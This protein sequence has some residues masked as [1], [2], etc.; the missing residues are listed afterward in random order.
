MLSD[1]DIRKA[2]AEGWVKI[3]P[4]NEADI[5]PSWVILHLGENFLI[6]RR[7]IKAIRPDLNGGMENYQP[8]NATPANPLILRPGDFV[9]GETLEKVSVGKQLGMVLS[10]K[11]AIARHGLTGDFTSPFIETG[12]GV[13]NPRHI[14][15]EIKN[16]SQNVIALVPGIPFTKGYFFKLDTPASRAS[17]D[18]TG[19]Y[20][21]N[22][23]APKPVTREP[24]P[25]SNAT[26][27]HAATDAKNNA[28]KPKNK[29]I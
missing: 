19:Y 15:L 24:S 16:A 8:F 25:K 28:A 9:L 4:L 10:T 21:V 29:G 11:S 1:V 23:G 13:P 12:T 14:T 17:D 18:D 3:E 20:D 26:T 5:K 2:L 7:S 6:P 22:V 27:S